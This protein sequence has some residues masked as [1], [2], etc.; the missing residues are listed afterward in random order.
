MKVLIDARILSGLSGGVEQATIGL[1]DSF[2]FT[3]NLGLDFQWLMYE[4][5]TDWLESHL[6][7]N[8]EIIEIPNMISKFTSK[9][10]FIEVIRRSHA[11]RHPLAYL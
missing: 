11:A 5:Q 1:A 3:E 2:C 4:G 10:K 9:K 8:S 6:P 7:K